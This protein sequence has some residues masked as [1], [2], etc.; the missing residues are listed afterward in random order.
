MAYDYARR[1]ALARAQGFDSYY[2]KR[3]TLEF[4]NNPRGNFLRVIGERAGGQRQAHYDDA[5]LYYQA[6]KE[7]PKNDYKAYTNAQ[8]ELVTRRGRGAR[9]KWLIEKAGYVDSYDAWL[10][11]YPN[12]KRE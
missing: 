3:R 11:L 4:A 12:G 8:G 5:R 10:A 9:A 1:D 7:G 6:F 2:D